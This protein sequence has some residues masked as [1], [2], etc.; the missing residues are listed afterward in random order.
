M[1]WPAGGPV[2]Q[3][4]LTT[5]K[6]TDDSFGETAQSVLFVMSILAALMCHPNIKEARP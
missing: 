6:S 5:V 1:K 2:N 4:I 3:L